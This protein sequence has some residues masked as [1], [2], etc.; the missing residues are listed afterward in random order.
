MRKSVHQTIFSFANSGSLY[1]DE[2]E[3][4]ER[5]RLKARTKVELLPPIRYHGRERA[6]V[7]VRS[8]GILFPYVGGNKQGMKVV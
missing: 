5:A 7:V 8:I 6:V 2:A 4:E 1:L 3:W